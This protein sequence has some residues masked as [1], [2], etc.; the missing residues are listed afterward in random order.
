M[1]ACFAQVILQPASGASEDVQ[2]NG[3]ATQVTGLELSLTDA[4]TWVS[5]LKDFYD[6]V[7]SL[8][9][10]RGLEQNN[11]LVKI[12]DI[13]GAAPN[14]PLYELTFDLASAVTNI[15]M[16]MELA[17]AVSYSNVSE[18]TVPRAR[19]RGRIYI[20]GWGDASNDQG[21]PTTAVYEGLATA[22]DDYVDAQNAV[23]DFTAGVWSRVDGLV[24]PIETV[25]CDNEWDTQRRRGGRPTARYTL[26]IP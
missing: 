22:Y 1:P 20:S 17:L 19:R 5:N 4:N 25:W 12:Y 11:H 16:P 15:G 21:R 14:Y 7:R 13:A 2:V 8:G 18:T 6:D 23:S 26:T 24:Y 9:G 10:C 3:F